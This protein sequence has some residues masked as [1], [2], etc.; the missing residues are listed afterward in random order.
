MLTSCSPNNWNLT[1]FNRFSTRRKASSTLKEYRV[2]RHRIPRRW[3]SSLKSLLF[4][5]S[6]TCD[7]HKH[8]FN[9]HRLVWATLT[10]SRMHS[11]TGRPSFFLLACTLLLLPAIAPSYTSSTSYPPLSDAPRPHDHHPSADNDGR[12]RCA[13]WRP[14]YIFS[15]SNVLDSQNFPK[16]HPLHA[17]RFLRIAV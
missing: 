8:R 10:H 5:P 2:L 15:Q 6:Q 9:L 4:C 3:I 14:P 1:S 7:H 17:Q 16:H 12:P 11:Q 13:H